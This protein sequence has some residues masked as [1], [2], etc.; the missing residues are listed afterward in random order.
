MHL[1]SASVIVCVISLNYSSGMD[2]KATKL[3]EVCF[4]Y[5]NGPSFFV[6]SRQRALSSFVGLFVAFESTFASSIYNAKN[7]PRST[8][9]GKV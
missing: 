7:L 2:Y 4:L 9:I 3:K 6:P 1:G 8:D 5:L